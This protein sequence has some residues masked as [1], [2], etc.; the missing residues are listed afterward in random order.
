MVIVRLNSGEQRYIRDCMGTVG[1]VSNPDNANTIWA[2]PAAT[3]GSASVRSRRGV[4]M[5]PVDHP[6]GGGEGRTSGGRHPVTP[7]GKPTKGKRTRTTRRPTSSS[8]G[9]VTRRRRG[10]RWLVPSG[11][12]RSSTCYLLKKA[13]AAQD[14][15]KQDCDQDLVASLHHPAAVR[16]PDLRRLQRP[17][18]YPRLRERGHGRPQA[19]RVCADAHLPG[20]AADKKA[21]G[22]NGQ[23]KSSP[24]VADN[25]ALAVGARSVRTSARRS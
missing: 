16:R 2:R 19:R 20:H 7:W 23:G 11:K 5:N 9:R 24:R 12:A 4:A 22:S 18:A 8:S 25:E 6:H 10:K 1:A 17:E 3:A 13:E 14:A 21:R 15:G